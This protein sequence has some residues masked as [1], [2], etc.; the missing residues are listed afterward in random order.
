VVMACRRFPFN[1]RGRLSAFSSTV[2]G[3]GIFTGR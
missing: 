1:A 2:T 3:S